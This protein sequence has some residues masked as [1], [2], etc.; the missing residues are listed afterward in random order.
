ML[1]PDWCGPLPPQAAP[2]IQSR[3]DVD[4]NPLDPVGD[5]LGMLA[6]I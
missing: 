2:V 1:R 3:A 6:Y 4:L 5:R